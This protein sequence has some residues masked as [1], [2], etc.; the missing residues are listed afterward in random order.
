MSAGLAMR[1]CSQSAQEPASFPAVDD[2][3]SIDVAYYFAVSKQRVSQLTSE[4]A[5][6]YA[7]S[8]G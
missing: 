8:V 2:M 6:H 7:E 3:R 4:Q 1:R 5:P